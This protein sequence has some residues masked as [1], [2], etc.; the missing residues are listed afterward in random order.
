MNDSMRCRACHDL[1]HP[2]AGMSLVGYAASYGGG[3]GISEAFEIAKFLG[4]EGD[5]NEHEMQDWF[6]NHYKENSV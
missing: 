3:G 6:R 5:E 4:Y 1:M 2:T